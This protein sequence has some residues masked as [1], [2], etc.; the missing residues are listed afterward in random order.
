MASETALA[1]VNRIIRTTGDWQVPL[2]TV[3]G[4]PGS[5][6]D[7]AIDFL[8]W[9]LQDLCK[10]IEFDVLHA[11]FTGTG[12]GVNSEFISSG[13]N[14]APDSAVTVTVDT[15]VL[16]EV[17]R[18]R[19]QEMR[20]SNYLVSSNSTLSVPTYYARTSDANNALGVDIYPTPASGAAITVL[21]QQS[22]T[23]FTVNDASTTEIA[24]NDL[25]ALGAIAHMDAFAGMERGYMQLYEDAKKRLWVN[26]YSN[27]QLK[28]VPEDYH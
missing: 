17:S 23:L 13:I 2:S 15:N 7:R 9:T 22:P 5:V 25:L 1:L 28:A 21:A 27:Q 26:N 24:E 4:S 6:A 20:A 14:A 16:E 11:S 3:V 18:R 12:D 19:L 10:I 8:N